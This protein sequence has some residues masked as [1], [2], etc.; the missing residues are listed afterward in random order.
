MINKAKL[1]MLNMQTNAQVDGELNYR[2]W[3]MRQRFLDKY[4]RVGEGHEMSIPASWVTNNTGSQSILLV[5]DE[6]NLIAQQ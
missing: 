3:Q 5:E 4:I 1:L 6:L 2:Y